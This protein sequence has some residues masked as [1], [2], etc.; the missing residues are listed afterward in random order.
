M[1]RVVRF[2]RES[3]GLVAGL[4][5]AVAV[6]G[7]VASGAIA[8]ILDR[9]QDRSAAHALAR[10]AE[11]VRAAVAAE[12]NRYVDVLHDLAV[13]IAAQPRLTA[14]DFARITA[15]VTPERLAGLTGVSLVVPADGDE[16]AAVQ[17]HW[18]R[19]GATDL[20]LRP[21]ADT[22]RQ[23]RF[24]V[25][26]RSFL[27]VPLA[28]G[29]DLAERPAW[30]EAMDRADRTGQVAVTRTYVLR[31]DRSLPPEQRQL[32]FAFAASIAPDDPD[33]VRGW[34]VMGMRGQDLLSAVL[35]RNS[36]GLVEVELYDGATPREGQIPVARWPRQGHA[37][38]D[39]GHTVSVSVAQ[40]DWALVA[41]GT[42]ELAA[43][44]YLPAVA[45]AVGVVITLLLTGLVLV[46][47][48]SR[49]RALAQVAAA[50]AALRADIERRE[51]TER[52]LR[53][54]DAE[55]CGFLAMTTHDL[56]GP[57]ASVTAYVELL[58]DQV[59]G[60][61]NDEGRADLGR[62][63]RGL[64]QMAELVED[65]LAYATADAA[66]L[67][68]TEVDLDALA[69]QVAQDRVGGA[70]PPVAHVR[71]GPLPTVVGDL[72]MLRR[73]LD[74]LI[75]N[76]IKYAA[77]GR[78]PEIEITADREPDGAHRI[79]V[80]DRG[81]GIPEAER[82]RVFDAFHRAHSGG[83]QAG[84]G[85]GLAICR[86]VVTRH[87]GAIGVTGNPGGGT[88]VWFTLPAAPDPSEPELAESAAPRR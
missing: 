55:L 50:T 52:Q 63:R 57:L 9:E 22:G 53:Q 14:T 27:P 80:A 42:N 17:A 67:R 69:R 62:I 24:A 35:E 36:Q 28:A 32:S 86:R 26:T 51:E 43:G 6:L 87:G 65:L 4:A 39:A 1:P 34:L 81:I 48:A 71:I 25:L 47:A 13:A 3:R 44:G 21:A 2:F 16:V 38:R 85:L 77:E 54:R 23:H 41:Y 49:Q 30:Y 72:G 59:D 40:R 8:V 61:L 74:N 45:G 37:A 46:L 60:T 68:R 79:E 73:L 56:R 12:T 10:R 20:V 33:G 83:E 78:V 88:R 75:G 76:A 19:R 7:L 11:L 84:S 15:A 29:Q 31:Q 82:S 18:R 66:P 70:A 58:A 64:T 5:S